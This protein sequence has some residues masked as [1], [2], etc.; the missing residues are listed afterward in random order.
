MSGVKSNKDARGP[1]CRAS[2]ILRAT[3]P[4]TI[5]TAGADDNTASQDAGVDHVAEV[6]KDE[7]AEDNAEA[8]DLGDDAEVDD[9]SEAEVDKAERAE[10]NAEAEDLGDYI[11]SRQPSQTSSG[12]NSY[13]P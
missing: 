11:Q 12:D 8:E 1:V 7:R 3:A 13:C 2:A 4:S 9:S 5:Q 6:D 10:D